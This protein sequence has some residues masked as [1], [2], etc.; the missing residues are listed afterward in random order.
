[1]KDSKPKGLSLLYDLPLLYKWM[2]F[3]VLT[4]SGITL[5]L[6]LGFPE[7]IAQDQ[8]E[9]LK[10][11]GKSQTLM[12]AK[13]TEES[14]RSRN[15]A[16]LEQSLTL[17]EEEVISQE[18][19][20]FE[21][22]VILF[23]SGYFYASTNSAFVGKTAH[24]S[25][26]KR[27][28]GSMD[29]RVQVS[30][31]SY[32]SLGKT[33]RAFQFTKD[34]LM[35]SAGS[36]VK[37]A[38]AQTLLGYDHIVFQVQK[39]IFIIGV[40]AILFAL[41]LIWVVAVPVIHALNRA[42][43]GMSAVMQKN[44]QLRYHPETKDEVGLLLLRFNQ[45]SQFLLGFY[46]EYQRLNEKLL[47]QVPGKPDTAL[48][49]ATVRKA[50]LTCLAAR[51]P[52]LQEVIHR[53]TPE[54][55]VGFVEQFLTNFN[56]RITESGGQVVKVL[57]DK[58]YCL[59]EGINGVNN[60][61]R[62]AALIS[63][64]WKGINHEKK[65]FGKDAFHYGIGLHSAEGISGNIGH[66]AD[67]YSFIGDGAK[68]AAFLC[69]AAKSGEILITGSMLEKAQHTYQTREV[70]DLPSRFLGIDEAII[71][72]Q[73]AGLPPKEAP[74]SIPRQEK[75]SAPSFKVQNAEG[76]IPDMMEETYEAAPLSLEIKNR[77]DE[78][79][80]EVNW[81]QEDF[82]LDHPLDDSEEEKK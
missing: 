57:G 80:E 75:K 50:E 38:S 77:M 43:E 32:H 53:E 18:L 12:V 63:Q 1:M 34:I 31:V 9:Q 37:V 4:L 65:V 15:V 20:L 48:D 27:L 54:H 62:A 64:T 61:L 76:G 59:F 17:L 29:K 44:F 78:P 35:D 22:S 46:Q 40:W 72:L 30:L 60:A 28:A 13:M 21:V 71:S 2:L 14:L 19:G 6:G 81:D 23:P 79:L 70:K 11:F 24:Q 41:A 56:N 3:A 52:G 66:G 42:T 68:V 82:F 7:R 8:L 74:N 67:S 16:L 25:L 73:E 39:K 49:I 55:I 10:V 45:M 36:K 51:L 69:S 47:E 58:V 33:I 5:L 26:L